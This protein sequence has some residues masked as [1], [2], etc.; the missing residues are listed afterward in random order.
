MITETS[1]NQTEPLMDAAEEL[2]KLARL[3]ADLLY[4]QGHRSNPDRPA[5]RPDPIR[6]M[7]T[8]AEVDRQLVRVEQFLGLTAPGPSTT[9]LPLYTI[10]RT[11]PAEVKLGE[12]GN[13]QCFHCFM[14]GKGD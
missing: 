5:P 9:G 6:A 14:S 11:C 13:G 8:L 7:A 1:P 10:C 3:T 4:F 2:R 12:N